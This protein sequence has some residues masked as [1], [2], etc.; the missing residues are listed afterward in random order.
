MGRV[1]F[2]TS[3]KGGV[4]KTTVSANLSALL[5]R[6]G[7]RVL[8][9]DGDMGMRCMDM[10]LG[11]ESGCVYSVAD[12][13]AGECA[14]ER[15][16]VESGSVK[17]LYF[18]ASPAQKPD[19]I[20]DREKFLSLFRKLREEYDYVIIDSSAEE[21]PYYLSFAACAD[22]AVVVCMH[23]SISVRAAEKTGLR[24]QDMGFRSVRLAVNCYRASRARAGELPTVAQMIDGSAIRLI[25][26]IPR[27][28]NV[29]IDQERGLTAFGAGRRRVSAY[30]AALYNIACRVTGENVPLLY[31]VD[32]PKNK[33]RYPRVNG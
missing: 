18:M 13:L 10:A 32:P 27:D 15:A 31:N 11:D 26:V 14:P 30:E 23:Q 8:A 28:D 20:P 9:V 19:M 3:F 1:L 24:L 17:G 2:I 21:T 12:V 16:V 33:K 4:V 29:V 25:G 5:A 22:D 7:H 6:M